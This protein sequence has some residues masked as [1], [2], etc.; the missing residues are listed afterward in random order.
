MIAIYF[1]N[2]QVLIV[3]YV[4]YTKLLDMLLVEILLELI[5]FYNDRLGLGCWRTKFKVA[6]YFV[7]LQNLLV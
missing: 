7:N 6:I 1:V 4:N 2:L 5:F 3:Y